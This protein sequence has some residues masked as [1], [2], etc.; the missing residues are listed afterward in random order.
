MPIPRVIRPA[1]HREAPA[2]IP[3]GGL[4]AGV[5]G[6]AKIAEYA[7]A[8]EREREKGARRRA[9]AP[10]RTRG[11]KSLTQEIEQQNR[12][13]RST[14]AK[15]AKGAGT[16]RTYLAAGVVD[17]HADRDGGR[18]GQ[19]KRERQERMLW[20]WL[21]CH[22]QQEIAEAVGVDRTVVS[23]FAADLWD[24]GCVGKTTKAS[25]LYEE[26]GWEPQ[27]YAVVHGARAHPRADPRGRPRD[28]DE[29][30]APGRGGPR[31]VRFARRGPRNPRKPGFPEA[32]D[33]TF[34]RGHQASRRHEIRP[35]A[36]PGVPVRR[37]TR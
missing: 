4:R 29:A 16:N 8:I 6:E 25:A 10:G 14:D 22:T 32:R 11:Q 19:H 13:A 33:P 9:Q 15:R 35:R 2:P 24:S 31:L 37:L 18:A 1:T 28:R 27:V 5:P 36:L 12:N 21:A 3:T 26:A 23:D 34:A 30:R 17:V 20:M 7:A